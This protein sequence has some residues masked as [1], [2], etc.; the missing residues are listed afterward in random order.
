[1]KTGI[2]YRATSPSGKCYVGQTILGLEHRKHGHKRDSKRFNHHFARAIRK[3]GIDIFKWE[4]ICENIPVKHLDENEIFYIDLCRSFRMGYNGDEGGKSHRGWKHTAESKEKMR[5]RKLTEETRKKMSKAKKGKPKSE[6]HRRKLS[7]AHKGKKHTAEAKKKISEARLGKKHTAET[8][9]KMS[10]IK[11]GK[12]KQ[13]N[14]E[15]RL[16][17]KGAK[18]KK[19]EKINFVLFIK[20]VRIFGQ[21][22][23]YWILRQNKNFN[24]ELFGAKGIKITY[25]GEGDRLDNQ[26][27]FVPFENIACITIE[28]N[29]AE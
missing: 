9:R 6:E 3:Y 29:E 11:K 14:M 5:G 25:I 2:I 18:M 16:R 15:I 27:S 17:K 13:Q 10:E 4:I 19:S 12:Y 24:V 23:K 28:N 20:E 8:K 7:K 1:M 22:M 26:Y 21:A